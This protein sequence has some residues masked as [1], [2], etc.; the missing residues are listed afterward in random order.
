MPKSQSVEFSLYPP[1]PEIKAIVH[2][3]RKLLNCIDYLPYIY[4]W[5]DQR[6]NVM[7]TDLVFLVRY[8][9]EQI[10]GVLCIAESNLYLYP[11]AFVISRTVL[12]TNIL[13]D[14]L[15]EPEDE[16]ESIIRYI[17]YLNSQLDYRKKFDETMSN[18]DFPQSIKD[19]SIRNKDSIDNDINNMKESAIHHGISPEKISSKSLPTISKMMDGISPPKRQTNSK[20]AYY[21]LSKFSH[22]M[23]Q[24]IY[25]YFQTD[26]EGENPISHW[27]YPLYNCQHILSSVERL[28]S[29]FADDK[30]DQ[31]LKDLPPILSELDATMN[32]VFKEN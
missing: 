3:L 9:K 29:R 31:F 5:D 15:L 11:S 2:L 19:K 24:S 17:Q 32:A 23:R 1:S 25:R 18:S 12:E 26:F 27:Y 20:I 10:E 6:M 8:Q 28:I 14:Y 16:S 22:A 4:P 30:L 7:L 13:I 21:E